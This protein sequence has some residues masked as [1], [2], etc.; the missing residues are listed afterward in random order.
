MLHRITDRDDHGRRDGTEPHPGTR[1]KRLP[2][3]RGIP[4][5]I[6]D[7][8]MSRSAARPLVAGC[9]WSARVQGFCA[10][11]IGHACSMC[12]AA[13]G[14]RLVSADGIIAAKRSFRVLGRTQLRSTPPNIGGTGFRREAI[15][16][17]AAV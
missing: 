11:G 7:W 13:E 15:R 9:S 16:S 1:C 6:R 2:W 4:S 10:I 3:A 12:G 17:Q 14:E 8:E 5:I